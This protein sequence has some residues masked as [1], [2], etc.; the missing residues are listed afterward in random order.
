M[1]SGYTRGERRKRNIRPRAGKKMEKN[2][3][4]IDP[5]CTIWMTRNTIII[6]I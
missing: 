4:E 6:I 2:I 1:K 3:D 5:F